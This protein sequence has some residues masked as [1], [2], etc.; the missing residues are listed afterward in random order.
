MHD[1]FFKE[2]EKISL[3]LLTDMKK[4]QSVILLTV[5]KNFDYEIQFEYENMERWQI[6]LMNGGAGIP[7]N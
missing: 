1:H 7:K 5:E 3:D 2:M 4:N 6:T